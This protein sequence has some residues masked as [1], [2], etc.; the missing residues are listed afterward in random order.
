MHR[1]T[2]LGKPDCKLCDAAKKIVDLV[3]SPNVMALIEQVDITKNPE[4][5]AKYHDDIPIILVDGVEKFR[6][7][8]DPD[9]LARLF[10]D[11]VSGRMPGLD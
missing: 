10:Y 11:Q 5:L 7:Q 1:I 3:V 8:V 4:L 9:A 2:I 6:G